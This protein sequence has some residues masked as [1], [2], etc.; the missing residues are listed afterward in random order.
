MKAGI[1]EAARRMAIAELAV[2][3]FVFHFHQNRRV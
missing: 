1:A 2:P 3:W